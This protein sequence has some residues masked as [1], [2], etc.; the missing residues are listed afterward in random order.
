MEQKGTKTIET[1]RL[2]LRAFR[3]EDAEPMFR[4][5]ASD[6][7]VTRFL[8]W[9]THPNPEVSGKVVE[10]WVRRSADL[11]FYQWAIVPK[12]SGEPIGS[13]SAVKTDERTESVTI[14]YCIGRGWWGQ[15]ITAEALGALIDF[16]F[17]EVGA[18]CLNACHDPRNPNSGRV[19][20]KCGMTYEGTWRAGGFNN[21]GVCDESWYSIL[22][23]EYQA[24]G[25]WTTEEE[26]GSP[27]EKR[28]RIEENSGELS[29]REE[30][31][32]ESAGLSGREEAAWEEKTREEKTREET[33]SVAGDTKKCI[34]VCA[35]DLTL[36]EIPLK[37][38]DL[39]IAVDGGLGYC[40]L[41]QVEPDLI[42]GDFDSVSPQE[43]E[44]VRQLESRIPDRI[45]RLP[46]EKD[47]TDTLAALKEGLRRGYTDFRIYGGMGGRFEHT[48]ANIQCLLY[49]KNRGAAGYLVDG[50]GMMFVLQNEK[51]SFR[52][53][54]EGYLSL[55]SLVE[56]SR[57]VTIEGMKYPLDRAVVCNDFP[58]GISN[59]FTGRAASVT[60]E[61]GTV[62]CVVSYA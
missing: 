25:T 29:G 6:P 35:G 34:L 24:Q 39:V 33:E 20:K 3:R 45:L 8:T 51:V 19:M 61:D 2:I 38:S 31:A 41:L 18:N 4:N 42:L 27:G 23:S 5:W 26:D 21:Q 44:A 62:V 14:G 7:E 12:E 52:E 15:G 58:I 11:A 30:K 59:E 13:I 22:R 50:D 46:A 1:E 37:E 60:V 40:G 28:S 43:A 48:L 53:G 36:G 47:D 56:E 57:G 9:P 32:K 49:L 54:T 10:D 16:F 17:K 55:F